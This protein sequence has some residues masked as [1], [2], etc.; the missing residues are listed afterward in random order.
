MYLECVCVRAGM[1]L[2]AHG[3]RTQHTVA[4]FVVS[5]GIALHAPGDPHRHGFI[6]ASAC[7]RLS[8]TG[9]LWKFRSWTNLLRIV[10]RYR[11]FF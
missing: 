4:Y 2:A 6:A 1:V 7:P 3:P 10:A 8:L 5:R 11:I 9:M